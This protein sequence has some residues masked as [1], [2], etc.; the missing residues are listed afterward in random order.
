MMVFVH[1]GAVAIMRWV[2]PIMGSG[3]VSP[4]TIYRIVFT[5]V[6]V[7]AGSVLHLAN[8]MTLLPG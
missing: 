7:P 5:A 6:D 4:I 3:W 2:V 1:L 8:T